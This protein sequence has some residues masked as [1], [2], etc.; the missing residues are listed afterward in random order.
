MKGKG[1]G[2]R[3]VAAMASTMGAGME[4]IDRSAGT[5]AR[6]IIFPATDETRYFV[7]EASVYQ[8]FKAHDRNTSPAYMVIKAANE[9]H[10]KTTRPDQMWQTDFTYVKIIGW[11][12][13]DCRRCSTIKPFATEQEA[14]NEV[15]ATI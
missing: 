14:W 7:S 10:T 15:M 11:G 4:Y 12:W 9:F 1:L 6:I 2:G 3:I 5:A 13:M 8:L